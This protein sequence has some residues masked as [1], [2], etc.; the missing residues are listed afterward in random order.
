MGEYPPDK[1]AARL[2][3]AIDA[4]NLSVDGR[5]TIY[6]IDEPG[7]TSIDLKFKMTAN[8]NMA[9]QVLYVE[10]SPT[11]V[12]MKINRFDASLVADASQTV[13]AAPITIVEGNTYRFFIWDADFLP[14]TA[15]NEA[16]QLL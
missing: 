7:K 2:K 10:Y 6:L 12:L 13:Q 14:L 15:K 11:G 1:V 8:V 4:L 5:L 3:A 16:A 9:A